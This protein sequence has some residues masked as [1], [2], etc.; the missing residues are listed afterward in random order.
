M[1]LHL[2]SSCLI[3]MDQR[4]PL[5]EVS[6][7]AQECICDNQITAVKNSYAHLCQIPKLSSLPQMIESLQ[8]R[9]HIIGISLGA[10]HTAHA[11]VMHTAN[12]LKVCSHA[13]MPTLEAHNAKTSSAASGLAESHT[14]SECTEDM[15]TRALRDSQIM[16][17]SDSQTHC[18]HRLVKH[19]NTFKSL[20]P[21]RGQGRLY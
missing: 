2:H 8:T 10:M 6:S 14:L 18:C 19:G 16:S 11:V 15:C 9:N 17:D 12:A 3:V 7:R 1:N 20:R 4:V 13:C 5:L 21:V